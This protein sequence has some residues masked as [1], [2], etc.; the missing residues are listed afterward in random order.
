MQFKYKLALHNKCL[1]Y[2][3]QKRRVGLRH[4][5]HSQ[6]SPEMDPTWKEETREA[7][8]NLAEKCDLRT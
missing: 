5:L 4:V 1:W 2:V 3:G 6:C 7:K 8:N